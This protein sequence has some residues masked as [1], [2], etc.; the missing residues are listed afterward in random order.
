MNGEDTLYT[1]PEGIVRIGIPKIRSGIAGGDWD[2]ILSL[3]A[4]EYEKPLFLQ[5]LALTVVEFK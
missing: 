3:I 1:V 4:E 2:V 5:K